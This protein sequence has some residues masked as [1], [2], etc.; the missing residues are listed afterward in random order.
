MPITPVSRKVISSGATR[1]G[2]RT[3]HRNSV[4]AIAQ[5]F[6]NDGGNGSIG[7]TGAARCAWQ[8][9]RGPSKQLV[10]FA[11]QLYGSRSGILGQILRG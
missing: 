4:S 11:I 7:V 6:L 10:P 1:P 5:D 8:G 3:H 9:N 2:V